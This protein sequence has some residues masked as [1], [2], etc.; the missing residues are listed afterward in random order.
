MKLIEKRREGS[1]LI[2]VHDAPKTPYQRVM[3]SAHV[4]DY[5]KRGLKNIY[6]KTNPFTLRRAID[7]RFRK[8]SR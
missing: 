2:R 8:L 5:N 4:S 1:K 3:E 7:T 6:E